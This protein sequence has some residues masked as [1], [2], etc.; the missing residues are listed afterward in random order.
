[1]SDQVEKVKAETF[2]E[3]KL[4][5]YSSELRLIKPEGE[6][7]EGLK[8]H[9]ACGNRKKAGFV[10]VDRLEF[11]AVD[12]VV[13]L[14][15]FPWPWEDDSV[16]EI[17]CEHYFE[18]MTNQDRVRFINECYRVLA[19]G[20]KLTILCPIWS[21]ARAYGDPTHVWPPV[22][23]WTGCY[24]DRDWRIKEAP[25]VDEVC[26]PNDDTLFRCDFQVTWGYGLH[27]YLKNRSLEHQKYAIAHN[28][29]SA[30][31]IQFTCIKRAKRAP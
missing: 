2:P 21:S 17:L 12:Q 18:H 7:P 29:E 23:E 6:L 1:V 16:S 26:D 19:M 15:K 27:N 5:N 9:L 24:W 10:N 8:L 20:G 14:I 3:P 25:H 11:E 13:D 4:N 30:Q 28:K 31:D 22:G